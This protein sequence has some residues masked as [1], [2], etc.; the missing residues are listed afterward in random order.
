MTSESPHQ[1]E[2]LEELEKLEAGSRARKA[3]NARALRLGALAVAASFVFFLRNDLRYAVQPATP[4]D[5]GGPLEFNLDREASQRYAKIQA[6]PGGQA[7]NVTHMGR[8]L[9]VFALLGTNVTVV[10]DLST[11]SSQPPVRGTPIAV[12]GRLVRDDDAVEL[13]NV[14]LMLETSGA[15][16][17]I[18]GHIY[19]LWADEAPRGSWTLPLEL[20]GIVLFVLVNFRAA[21]RMEKPLPEIVDD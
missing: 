4:V 20:V 13:R 19:A 21:R 11:G 5:L 6:V 9:R 3:R 12:S 8:Q 14:F 1:Q 15:V 16:A 7:A 18:D 10:Q 2:L 17:R